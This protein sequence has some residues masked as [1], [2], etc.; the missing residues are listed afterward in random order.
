M[1][2]KIFQ[3]YLHQKLSAIYT[4]DEIRNFYF[5]LLEFYAKKTK[6]EVLLSPDF[7]LSERIKT[8]I[9]SASDRLITQEPIQYILGETEFFGNRFLV[10]RHVLIP[11][12][13]TEELVDWIL[14]SI[15]QNKAI[16]ILDIGCGSGAIAISLAKAL[17]KSKVEAWDISEEALVK[18]RENALLNQVTICLSQVDILHTQKLTKKYDVIVSNPPYVRYCEK[19]EMQRNVLDYEPHL[20]L[21]VSDENPLIFYEK[22]TELAKKSLNDNGQLFFEINQYLSK[23][24]LKM[25][26]NKDFKPILRNDLNGNPRM[27]R[28]VL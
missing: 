19:Q 12:Q 24:T 21:F 27:I 8:Q 14:T 9:L 22:I 7:E 23:D 18:A 10:D 4:A 2:L 28:A 17:P 3:A 15:P 16:S 5:L 25:L 20:A 6:V 13:E 1:N 26:E 11:R